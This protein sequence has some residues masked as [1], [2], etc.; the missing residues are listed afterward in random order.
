MARAIRM[1]YSAQ[2]LC[3]FKNKIT[4]GTG[5]RMRR[6][7][8]ALVTAAALLLTAGSPSA[9]T[10][11]GGELVK[12]LE[13][14]FT[15]EG[16]A[17]VL[18]VTLNGLGPYYFYLDTGASNLMTPEVAEAL[19]V[20]QLAAGAISGFGPDRPE[21]TRATVASVQFGGVYLANQ[22]FKVLQFPLHIVDRGNRPRLAGLIGGDFLK[23]FVAQIDFDRHVVRFFPKDT[24]TYSGTGRPLDLT[25]F[26][27]MSPEGERWQ[28]PEASATVDGKASTLFFDTGSG[29]SVIFF[30][31]TARAGEL[32]AKPGDRLH[33]ISAG[34]IGGRVKMDMIRVNGLE[35]AGIPSAAGDTPI[36]EVVTN[37][38][39]V[40]AHGDMVGALGMAL[41]RQFNLTIDYPR[42]KV[43]L[44]PRGSLPRRDKSLPVRG[45][46][47]ELSKDAHDRFTVIG[48]ISGSPAEKAGIVAGDEI[49]SVN[50]K[51]VTDMAQFD[52]GPIER[53]ELPVTI[54][55]GP[56]EN[57]RTITL[58]KQILM[59]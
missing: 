29:G 47:L 16:G 52:Y 30:P 12:A 24:F 7:C 49:F 25:F 53:S 3:A 1:G 15:T 57:R 18:T 31:G 45:T 42:N 5:R 51:P 10:V 13:V 46:G 55:L 38:S 43:Y 41:L 11:V 40:K 50:D 44:E 48:V 34:G 21:V 39:G 22:D 28:R 37:N 54:V 20:R 19:H 2:C 6:Y 9:Q 26:K 14:P 36:I 4:I 35:L 32:L 8:I 56:P 17:I 27:A 33:V 58:E 59:P 23:D